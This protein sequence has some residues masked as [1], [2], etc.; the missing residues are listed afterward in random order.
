MC[1]KRKI[2]ISVLLSV[3]FYQITAGQGKVVI[4]GWVNDYN[5]KNPEIIYSGASAEIN[6][7][8]DVKVLSE[9]SGFFKTEIISD[10]PSY[11]KVG[12][13]T[14][15]LKPGDSVSLKLFRSS[16]TTEIT[17][18]GAEY[19]NYLK[20]VSW[21][22]KKKIFLNNLGVSYERIKVVIDS[23][24]VLRIQDLNELKLNDKSL[25]EKEIARITADRISARLTYANYGRIYDWKDSDSLKNVK[26]YKFYG[27]FADEINKL[28]EIIINRD[29]YLDIESV[30]KVLLECKNYDFFVRS[31]SAGFTELC[32]VID[33]SRLMDR[34]LNIK[35]YAGLKSYI[36]KISSP[37]L[38]N[39]FRLKF[40]K[41][42]AL[43]E[44]KAA[45]DF[46]MKDRNGKVFNLSDLKGKVLYIDLWATWCLPCLAQGPMYTELSKKYRS[47]TFVAIS[48]DEDEDKWKKKIIS[49][50][51]ETIKEFIADQSS[52]KEIW[53]LRTIPRFILIDKNFRIITAFAPRPSEKME[54]EEYLGYYKL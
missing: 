18:D 23:F 33:N 14:V 16:Q 47:I 13:N 12:A 45:F 39:S 42:E 36:D 28:L 29:D 38:K 22:E 26:L 43:M 4:T 19:N 50:N 25:I 20:G 9:S 30:R 32:S 49:E 6:N 1:F 17:G 46:E 10:N 27:S 53:E 31:N 21:V 2:L 51:R 52:I 44:G 24:A 8:K 34:G 41:R 5:N 7:D 11:Y 3:L 40:L 54:I 35:D 48:I 37:E 15:Y